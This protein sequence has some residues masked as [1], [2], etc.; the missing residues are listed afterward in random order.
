MRRFLLP[1]LAALALPNAVNAEVDPAVHNLCKDVSDYMGCV[2]A[3][4]KKGGWNSF[5]KSTKTE[6]RNDFGFGFFTRF[7]YGLEVNVVFEGSPADKAGLKTYDLIETLNGTKLN[8]YFGRSELKEI[9]D[10]SG[11]QREMIV[12][13]SGE[14][15][16]FKIQKGKYR[17]TKEELEMIT[18]NGIPKDW[19]KNL[20]KANKL[21]KS[22]KKAIGGLELNEIT[23]F[24]KKKASSQILNYE[25]CMH[26]Y[27]KGWNGTPKPQLDKTIHKG[28]TYT[29]S[30]ICPVGKNMYWQVNSGFM[31]KSKVFELGCMTKAENEEYWRNMELRKAGTP[32]GGSY[33]SDGYFIKQQMHMNR[34]SDNYKRALDNYG[35]NHG[36]PQY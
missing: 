10:K 23:T 21:R 18:S 27:A 16:S 22:E 9:F 30:R 28:K 31:R 6:T 32:K 34:M 17:I 1:L 12:L 13:R 5:K 26:M 35:R 25:S 29:A 11:N 15:L 14:K 2:K 8:K 19:N 24:C 7:P 33:N 20:F 36:H 3:N 4:S